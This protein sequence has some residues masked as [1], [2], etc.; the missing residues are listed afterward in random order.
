MF[1][2]KLPV[3]ARDVCTTINQGM[4]VNDFQ[5]VRGGD[6][7]QRDSHCSWSARYYYRSTH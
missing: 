6:E 2:D 1:S 3:N 7:L 5:R 4:S